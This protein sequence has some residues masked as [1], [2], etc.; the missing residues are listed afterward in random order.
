MVRI[1]EFDSVEEMY[2]YEQM[3]R[4][5]LPIV[6]K[7]VVLPMG[8]PVKQCDA[9]STELS[10][11]Q[12]EME[13]PPDFI[14]SVRIL[15]GGKK[16][17]LIS[18]KAYKIQQYVLEKGTF[19]QCLEVECELFGK[20]LRGGDFTNVHKIFTSLNFPVKKVKYGK[21]TFYAPR[22]KELPNIFSKE[23][24]VVSVGSK[25]DTKQNLP[26]SL[27][28]QFPRIYPVAEESLPLFEEMVKNM[29]ANKGRIGLFDVSHSVKI[30]STE[31]GD[32]WRGRIWK[33]FT[34]QFMLNSK[35]IAEYFN[36]PDKFKTT[37]ESGFDYVR[38]G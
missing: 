1:I 25:D 12:V 13:V 2:A 20:R 14:E 3:K 33:V 32:E 22:L 27:V 9:E 34:I 21:S 4:N 16:V 10:S 15:L 36:V 38:Y 23:Q 29:I 11:K 17:E 30:V 35:K 24:K 19:V 31:H 8:E 18:E 28:E 37:K 26:E 6:P 5:I 7:K